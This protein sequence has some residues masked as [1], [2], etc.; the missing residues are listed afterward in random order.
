MDGFKAWIRCYATAALSRA[1]RASDQEASPSNLSC[2]HAGAVEGG[3]KLLLRSHL[4]FTH[5]HTHTRFSKHL[6]AT[7]KKTHTIKTKS[8]EIEI[9]QPQISAIQNIRMLTYTFLNPLSACLIA[10]VRHAPF[11]YSTPQH[12]CVTL[13]SP[14]PPSPSER[15]VISHTQIL[16]N[17]ACVFVRQR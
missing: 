3:R 7:F 12:C 17:P 2:A 15:L 16:T 6:I 8:Y 4:Q 1:R 9:Q 10:R 5:T 14:R 11:C 13:S